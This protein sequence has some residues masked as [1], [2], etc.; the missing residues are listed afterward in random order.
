[1]IMPWK[2]HQT[3]YPASFFDDLQSDGTYSAREHFFPA[4]IKMQPLSRWLN[5]MSLLPVNQQE[6]WLYLYMLA[7]V[8][9]SKEISI[10]I[11]FTNNLLD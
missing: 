4:I 1:M 11:L 10:I 8:C 6:V 5:Y 3:F 2:S 9:K 7:K